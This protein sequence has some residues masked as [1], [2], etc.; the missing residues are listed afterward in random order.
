[1]CG[2]FKYNSFMQFNSERASRRAKRPKEEWVRP[3]QR[4]EIAPGEALPPVIEAAW[5]KTRTEIFSK[6]AYSVQAPE[7]VAEGVYTESEMKSDFMKIVERR[8][9]WRGREG[10]DRENLRK[11]AEVFEAVVAKSAREYG[12]FDGAQ[13]L[14]ASTFDDVMNGADLFL[15]WKSESAIPIVI[16]LD[17]T[18]S[19]DAVAKKIAKMKAYIDQGRLTRIKY[20]K[21]PFDGTMRDLRG[22]PH[23]V[24]GCEIS[25]VLE[26]AQQFV[27]DDRRGVAFS[28][29]RRTICD[30]VLAQLDSFLA[31]AEQYHNAYPAQEYRRVRDRIAA[32][33]RAAGYVISLKRE[34]G[35]ERAI[36]RELKSQLAPK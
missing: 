29:I 6:H 36:H 33:A 17:V 20:F 5:K 27:G 25:R 4:V 12:W 1:M 16:A 14:R 3:L 24:V 35:V 31:Y 32:A 21:N 26:L 15:T 8:K 34:D 2:R 23:F 11:V 28:S 18:F 13:A 9:E 7:F 30:E 19:A 10:A 22:A